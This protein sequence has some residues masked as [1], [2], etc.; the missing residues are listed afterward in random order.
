MVGGATE[1]ARRAARRAVE[2]TYDGLCTIVERR[3]I[4]DERTK[5]SRQGE[6]TV[7]EKQPCRLSYEKLNIVV[8][9]DAAAK[10]SQGVKLFMAPEIT[11]RG[12]SKIIVEQ[13]GKRC[14][15]AASGEPAVHFSHQEIPLELFRSWA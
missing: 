4:K 11:V 1:R 15:Y 10:I 12:G 2:S 13:D 6:V 3:D 5:L 14:E 9:T 8:Q 7:L